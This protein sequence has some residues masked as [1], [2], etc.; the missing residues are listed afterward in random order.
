MQLAQ[1]FGPKEVE[2]FITTCDYTLTLPEGVTR[3][4]IRKMIPQSYI[5]H[6]DIRLA[7]DLLGKMLQ[8]YPKARISV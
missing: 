2:E 3:G 4:D 5:N 7:Y 6:K 1:L 8:L